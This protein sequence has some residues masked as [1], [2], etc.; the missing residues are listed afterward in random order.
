MCIHSMCRIILVPT[1]HEPLFKQ[2]TDFVDQRR[3]VTIETAQDAA[4]INRK[5]AI[6]I[7]ASYC[8]V[9]E[10]TFSR[11]PP[12][13]SAIHQAKHACVSIATSYLVELA[14]ELRPHRPLSSSSSSLESSAS[15]VLVSPRYR[16]QQRHSRC[17]RSVLQLRVCFGVVIY[18]DQHWSSLFPLFLSSS[19]WSLPFVIRRTMRA[20]SV[21][22]QVTLSSRQ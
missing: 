22:V 21:E 11:L 18:R 19:T 8:R 20:D 2:R 13:P 16:D 15:I 9:R 3:R 10:T 6:S 5:A 12:R 1:E 7:V 17:P 4:K 14:E